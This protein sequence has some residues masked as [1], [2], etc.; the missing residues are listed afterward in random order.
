MVFYGVFQIM[1]YKL[2]IVVPRRAAPP[3]PPRPSPS[4][5][6]TPHALLYLHNG[7]FP[8]PCGTGYPSLKAVLEGVL[9]NYIGYSIKYICGI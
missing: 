5:V 1:F 2:F 7:I 4:M 3:T 6:S 8:P 9:K